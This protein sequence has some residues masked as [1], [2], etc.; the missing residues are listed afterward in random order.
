MGKKERELTTIQPPLA[1]PLSVRNARSQAGAFAR[2]DDVVEFAL[3]GWDGHPGVAVGVLGF[4]DLRGDVFVL[5]GGWWFVSFEPIEHYCRRKAG[6]GREGL[7]YQIV[8]ASG[9]CYGRR[10]ECDGHLCSS[11]VHLCSR[12]EQLGRA[13]LVA[14]T[15]AP[16]GLLLLG[17]RR[18]GM[19]G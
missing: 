13:R 5:G 3:A 4:A 9:K 6:G 15:E 17:G 8:E 1:L 16:W 19:R 7:L 10:N 12:R 2:L 11:V 18:R 14:S